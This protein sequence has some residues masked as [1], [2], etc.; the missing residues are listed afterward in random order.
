[1]IEKVK[2]RKRHISLRTTFM[3]GFPGE[4]GR[5]FQE[6][7]KFVKEA[8]FDHLGA[9]AF[10]PEKGTAADRL[11]KK[12]QGERAQ[13]RLE[14]IMNLQ[15]GISRKKNLARVG[16]TVVTLLEGASPETDLLLSGRTAGMAPD[17]DGRVLINKGTGI[18]GEMVSVRIT[19]GQPYDLIGEIL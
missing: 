8:E 3:V 11:D 19:D 2:A 6:L 15:M 5:A 1:L 7:Y 10:S 12:V 4:T 14:A 13:E 18:V 9:F 17:V 16:E